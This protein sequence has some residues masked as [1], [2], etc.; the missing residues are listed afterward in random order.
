MLRAACTSN[1]KRDGARPLVVEHTTSRKCDDHARSLRRFGHAHR[2]LAE[3]ARRVGD[4]DRVHSHIGEAVGCGVVAAEGVVVVAVQELGA[5]ERNRV[6][7]AVDRRQDVVDL[8][9]IRVALFSRHACFV[10]R[11]AHER[12][13][14]DQHV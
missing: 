13:H 6:R 4:L 11:L 8:E 10:C 5:L 7:D 12:L 14:L 2:H 1:L 9:L 3:R